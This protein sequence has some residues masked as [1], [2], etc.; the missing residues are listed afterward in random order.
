VLRLGAW[1]VLDVLLLDHPRRAF[2]VLLSRN[3][4]SADLAK[5]RRGAQIKHPGRF[6]QCD[7]ATRGPL[8]VREDRNSV[9]VAEATYTLLR[10][11]VQPAGSLSCSVEHTRNGFVGHQSRA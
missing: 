5:H 6:S 7:F 8:A 4:A 3:D 2:A 10:P 9:R 1:L 11:S